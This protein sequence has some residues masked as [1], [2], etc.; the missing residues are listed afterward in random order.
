MIATRGQGDQTRDYL[1]RFV[2]R[3]GLAGLTPVYDSGHLTRCRDDDSPLRRGRVLVAGDAAGLLEPWTREGISFA[4]RSGALAGTAAARGELAGYPQLVQ[5]R[6]GVEMSAGRELL[7]A[8]RAHPGLFHAMLATPLG[9]RVFTDFCRGRTS[10]D[11]V[12]QRR[13]VRL[14]LSML[15]SRRRSGH[16]H[17]PTVDL[18]SA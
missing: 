9:W 15:R 4:L 6:L 10:L 17:R 2:T 16:D 1:R 3:L 13:P 18:S 8:F 7:A 11:R 14:A 5:A 12:V